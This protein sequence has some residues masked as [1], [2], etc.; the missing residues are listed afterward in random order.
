MTD[1]ANPPDIANPRSDVTLLPHQ[2][3]GVRWMLAREAED[4]D[5]CRGGIL[6]DDMGLGK[7]FQT[8]ALLK[9]SPVQ[10]STLLVC[11]PNL[12][13]G[14]IE[15]L[16][17]C[18]FAVSTLRSGCAMWTAPSGSGPTVHIT[19]Y[20][21]V[22]LYPTFLT[23]GAFQ[24]IILDEGHAIRNGPGNSTWVHAMNISKPALCRWILSATPIHNSNADWKHLCWW[25]RVR[26]PP[27]AIAR[28]GDVIMFRRT[29]AELRSSIAALPPVPRFV[30]HDLSIPV[31]TPEGTL[32][33][34]LC[35]QLESAMDDSS[36]KSLIKLVL[37]MR[38]QQFLVHPQIYINSMRAS[39]GGAYSRPDWNTAENGCGGDGATKWAACIDDLRS[40]TDPTIVFCNFRTEMEALGRVMGSYGYRVFTICGGAKVAEVVAAAKAATAAG[41]PVIVI[42]QIVCG[43][44]GLNLQFCRRIFFLSQHWN[45]A[46]IHQAVGRAVRI[47]Q[48]AVVE[49]HLY[50]IVDDV[51]EN[52]D[53][54][55]V[56][57]HLRKIAAAKAVSKSLYEGFAPISE[58][59][60]IY[61]PIPV[62]LTATV[63]TT[64]AAATTV[65]EVS[66]DPC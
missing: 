35:D 30:L 31:A 10:L 62:P 54:R 1:I 37:Y 2:I 23:T 52:I 48:S 11:P 22:R 53:R 28:V 36:V 3:A 7:T 66:E 56:H 27:S 65:S 20:P 9:N 39:M 17:S 50:R 4:A 5:V 59:P 16:L 26:C 55:M 60:S 63:A 43:G 6:G 51:L 64:V 57:L 33:R 49:V 34:A 61:V 13:A 45:P 24:R 38:I 58:I 19:T 41:E 21:K 15:E 14:W 47:G 44:A 8:I 12:V 25:L 29:M 46:V 18:G 40:S 32:F 42:V